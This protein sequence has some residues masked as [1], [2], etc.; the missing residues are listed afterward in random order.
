MRSL[1][2]LELQD[3]PTD[4]NRLP[5]V[6]LFDL[7]GHILLSHQSSEL[8]VVVQ[9]EELVVKSLN[10]S[11]LPRHRDVCNADLALVATT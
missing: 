3:S 4:L 7:E 10:V 9:N 11:V 6:V 1:N 2:D 8:G 5:L